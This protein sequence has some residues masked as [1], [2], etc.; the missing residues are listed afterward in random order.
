MNAGEVLAQ[1]GKGDLASISAALKSRRLTSPFSA[2]ALARLTG[3][4]MA[5]AVAVALQHIVDLG[6]KPESLALSIDLLAQALERRPSIEDAA[7]LVMTAPTEPAAYHRDTR[8]VVTDLFRRTEYTMLV[9]GYAVHQGKKIFEE[10]A[11]RM[12]LKPSLQ[13][14]LFLNLNLRPGDV[15]HSASVARFSREFKTHHWPT[16][17]RLPEVFFDRRAL[18]FTSGPSVAFHAKCVIRDEVELFV[19]SANFTEAAQNRN[20]EMG[21][22]L[23]SHTL[24]KQATTFFSELINNG[25]CERCI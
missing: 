2:P 12:R 23:Q 10:L 14:R 4:S 25:V 20:I 15:S 1:L 24:A 22:L 16:E 5:P 11:S 19:S 7:Q 18:T 8:V 9:A 3:A 17:H 6:L 13:V 21:I